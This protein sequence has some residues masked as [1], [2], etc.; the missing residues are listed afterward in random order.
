MGWAVRIK[1][2]LAFLIRLLAQEILLAFN[3]QHIGV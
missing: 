1:G 2:Q 3:L